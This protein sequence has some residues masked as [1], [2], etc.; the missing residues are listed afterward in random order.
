M[1]A[2][3]KKSGRHQYLQIVHNERLRYKDLL[4]VESLFRSL[5][6]ILETRPI[7]HKCDDTI[8][9]HVFCS[10]LALLLM[11]ELESRLARRGWRVE[12]RRLLDDLDE[13]QEVTIRVEE[14]T[15]VVRTATRG[16]AGK[17]LQAA[18]VALGPSIRQQ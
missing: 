9:G 11:K 12:W 14:K 6:S 13:L 16:E 15:F 4:W 2:R 7:Y 17:A 18:G 5:K 10:F 1:F 3:V 8:R